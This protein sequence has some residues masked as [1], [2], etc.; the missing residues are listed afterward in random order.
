MNGDSQYADPDMRA[1]KQKTSIRQKNIAEEALRIIAIHGL[2][3]VGIAELAQ[4]VGLVP[5]G[6]YRH[7]K[8]KEEII[9][10]VFDSIQE[11]LHAIVDGVS[12]STSDPLER[13]RRILIVHLDLIKE[14]PAIPRIVFSE[15][16]F[17]ENTHRRARVREIVE[18]YLE[19]VAKIIYLGQNEG[20]L[21]SDIEPKTLAVMF[22]GLIQPLIILTHITDG[23]LDVSRHVQQAW[24]LF[25]E[26]IQRQTK[27]SGSR[28]EST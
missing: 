25:L 9:D 14:N 27:R 3:G 7:F 2:T 19:K 23:K 26:L 28:I 16:I 4:R 18:G 21:R 10:S 1:K 8:S 20:K 5:S 24:P 11:R 22:L 6:I 13:L 15:G 12:R 17:S